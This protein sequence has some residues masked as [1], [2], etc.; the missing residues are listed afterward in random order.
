M[1][2]KRVYINT[3]HVSRVRIRTCQTR[4]RSAS[5]ALM[6]SSTSRRRAP[7]TRTK[8]PAERPVPVSKPKANS[9]QVGVDVLADQLATGLRLGDPSNSRG[10]QKETPLSAEERRVVAMRSVN[11]ALQSLSTALQAGGKATATKQAS[12]TGVT[13]GSVASSGESALQSL[14]E[15]RRV[16]SRGLD[17]ERA[18][19]GVAA[20]LVGLEQVLLLHSRRLE[21]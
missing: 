20:K 2:F 7:S 13:A 9:N 14:R 18:A 19:L 8:R 4:S 3:P 15:L 11:A 16:G 12:K 17:T 5:V 6:S 21:D 1:V 10:K